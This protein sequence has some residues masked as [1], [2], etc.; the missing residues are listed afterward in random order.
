MIKIKQSE[1]P[2][3]QYKN[4]Q[5]DTYWQIED[6]KSQCVN[7]KLQKDT[8]QQIKK[9]TESVKTNTKNL[10]EMLMG[11]MLFNNRISQDTLELKDFQTTYKHFDFEVIK[12]LWM[13]DS[14]GTMIMMNK[15][16]DKIVPY[17]KISSGI[18][19]E[20]KN[21]QFSVHQVD[22]DMIMFLAYS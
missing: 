16:Q 22:F 14:K 21:C 19:D 8:F 18:L 13:M 4:F 12:S 9:L 15:S 7:D 6:I 11:K 2:L 3:S 1:I 10:K 20:F 17:E 5:A